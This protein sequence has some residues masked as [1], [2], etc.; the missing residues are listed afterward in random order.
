MS[1][2]AS[3]TA[4]AALA[5]RTA[6]SRAT[7]RNA[8]ILV[9][10]DDL[11]V[12]QVV[13]RLL[14]R[15]GAQCTI[16]STGEEALRRLQGNADLL[17]TDASM[18]VMDGFELVSR[19]RSGAVSPEVP[20]L[21]LTALDDPDDRIHG[22]E[23]GVNEHLAKPFDPRELL[24]RCERLLSSRDEREELR[25]Q[26]QALAEAVD[27]RTRALD[28]AARQV[29]AAREQIRQAQMETLERL[30]VSAEYRDTDTFAHIQRVGELSALLAEQAGITTETVE[31]IRVAARLHDIGKIG[32]PDAI[33]LK[34]GRLTGT[35]RAIMQEHTRIGADILSQSG[36]P[37]IQMAEQ[38]ALTH[39]E[40]WNGSGYPQ[41][42]SGD[43]IPLWGRIC[44]VADVFDALTTT[45]PYKGA[46]STDEA[47][48]LLR[49]GKGTQFEPRLV[50]IL[51]ANRARIETIQARFRDQG[52]P[53]LRRLTP[54][55]LPAV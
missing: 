4:A 22:M 40:W 17:I 21:M 10:D 31:R 12:A 25:R 15:Y 30:A 49:Q 13:A 35:E 54:P 24:L 51:I 42:L 36:I 2:Q 48:A 53:H 37:A 28:R 20:V 16:A 47:F 43:Q 29:D 50:D 55:P 32:I 3:L 39:H 27:E 14:E 33:L 6:P 38:I 41:G 9:V 1:S 46:L 18:P 19:V 5:T 44:A 8:N 23:V 11:A 45:R 34:P 52:L 7:L 26:K